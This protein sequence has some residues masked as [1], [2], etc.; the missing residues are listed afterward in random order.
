MDEC[1]TKYKHFSE[2]LCKNNE[3]TKYFKYSVDLRRLRAVAEIV[4]FMGNPVHYAE[5][6]VRPGYFSLGIIHCK[7]I[8]LNKS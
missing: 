5:L 3:N 2:G 4:S 6:I 1:K 7:Q 8:I